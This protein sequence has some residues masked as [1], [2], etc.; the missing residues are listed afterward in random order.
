[1][2]WIYKIMNSEE[3]IREGI[4]NVLVRIYTLLFLHQLSMPAFELRRQDC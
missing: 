2:S 4:G 1:M 3:N